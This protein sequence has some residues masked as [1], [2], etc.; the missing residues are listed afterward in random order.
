MERLQVFT[1]IIRSVVMKKLTLILL[2][3]PYLVFAQGGE[4]V[5]SAPVPVPKVKETVAVYISGKESKE[6]QGMHS[7]L[8]GELVRAISMSGGYTAVDRTAQTLA[9]L[10]KEHTYQRGGAVGDEYIIALGRQFAAQYLCI[11]EVN[12]VRGG[13]YYLNVRL[14]DAGSALTKAMATETSTLED[15]GEMRRV[16]Q[17]LANTLIGSESG[18]A[19]LAAVSVNESFEPAPDPITAR[20]RRAEAERAASP[21]HTP[22]YTPET[23]ENTQT[24]EAARPAPSRSSEPDGGDGRIRYGGRL[25]FSSVFAG[26]RSNAGGDWLESRSSGAFASLGLTMSVPV[27]SVI[28]FN[29]ELLFDVRR[30]DLSVVLPQENGS[31]SNDA[32]MEYALCL[33]LIVRFEVSWFY[34]EAGL[35]FDYPLVSDFNFANNSREQIDMGGAAGAGFTFGLSS[36]KC[37]LGYRFEGNFTDFD[38]KG[39]FRFYRHSVGLTSLF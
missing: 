22:Q 15:I 18:A 9:V 14:V 36:V 7:V 16:A 24:G 38:E 11:A 4:E 10:E 32:M 1:F 30:M 31:Y 29:P 3:F 6:S 17:L 2:F 13:H 33:P 26:T 5:N 34:A 39:Y 37:Y 27:A 19:A 12:A 20:T 23:E 35:R 8:G 28:S 25:A 21:E